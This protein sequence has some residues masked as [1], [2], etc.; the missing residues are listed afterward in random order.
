MYK[1]ALKNKRELGYIPRLQQDMFEAYRIFKAGLIKPGA[2]ATEISELKNI[3][4][5]FG[6][7]V[8]K[9]VPATQFFNQAILPALAATLKEVRGV[10]SQSNAELAL[11]LKYATTADKDP[12]ALEAMIIHAIR[13]SE[14]AR[15]E[16]QQM[17]EQL[18]PMM[19]S[20]GAPRGLALQTIIPGGLGR[21][22]NQ[23]GPNMTEDEYNAF[24]NRPITEILSQ[25]DPNKAAPVI[26]P[27]K[28][29]TL[30]PGSK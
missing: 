24:F 28:A 15:Q 30:P 2:F 12:R 7:T 29:I 16:Q 18:E 22:S 21:A 4:G 9:D 26:R 25:E 11:A 3:A 1:D 5:R 6:I 17:A 23:A 19:V 14:R 20:Q 10:G 27:P 13:G 8:P